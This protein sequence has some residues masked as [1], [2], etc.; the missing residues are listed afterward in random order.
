MVSRL[1]SLLKRSSGG[2]CEETGGDHRWDKT[3][4]HE[5]EELN[6]ICRA[7]GIRVKKG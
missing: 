1:L 6:K 2:P 5:G 7:C 3:V 4:N